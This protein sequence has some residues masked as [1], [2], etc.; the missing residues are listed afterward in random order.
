MSTRLVERMLKHIHG[1]FSEF[2]IEWAMSK[3]FDENSFLALGYFNISINRTRYG[4]KAPDATLLAN[5]YDEIKKRLCDRGSHVS[6]F[7]DKNAGEIALAVASSRYRLP[8]RSN[9]FFGMDA[10]SFLAEIFKKRLLWAPDGNEAFDDGSHILQFDVDTKVRLIGF[11]NEPSETQILNSVT[12]VTLDGEVY[13]TLLAD[14]ISDF[15]STRNSMLAEFN[16]K[17]S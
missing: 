16:S 4:V 6:T 1:D 7:S 5:T 8:V 15:D 13:Y 14:W 10:K 9:T 2:C 17:F 12:D 11:K 3:P